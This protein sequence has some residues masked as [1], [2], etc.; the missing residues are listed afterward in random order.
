[1]ASVGVLGAVAAFFVSEWFNWRNAYFAGGAMGLLL[2]I[3]RVGTFESGMFKG[4]AERKV[5][6]GKISMLFNDSGRFS[7]YMYCLLICLPIWFVVGILVT[8]APEF[9]RALGAPV[10]LSAGKGILF[11]YLGLSLGDMAAGLFAQ[12]TKSRR[13]A[14]FIFQLMIIASTIWYLSSNGITEERFH[15]IAFFMGIAIGYWAT[16]VTIASEQFGTNLRA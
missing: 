5:E 8:Q 4:V 14:V 2:L 16:F 15:W 7:R 11:T 10:T 12:I 13:L 1:V 9:G 3:L 6:R